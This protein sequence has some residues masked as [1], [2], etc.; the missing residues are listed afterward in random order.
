[1]LVHK[2]T[3]FIKVKAYKYIEIADEKL[4]FGSLRA[5]LDGILGFA[6]EQ[7]ANDFCEILGDI[8]LEFSDGKFASAVVPE[9]HNLFIDG[10]FLGSEFNEAVKKLETYFSPVINLKNK[11]SICC[12]KVGLICFN[13]GAGGRLFVCSEEYYNKYSSMLMIMEQCEQK[14]SANDV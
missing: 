10:Y 9:G 13:R 12:E 6:E 8:R 1:M 4:Y 5:S 7:D 2:G 11:G 14:T 3:D